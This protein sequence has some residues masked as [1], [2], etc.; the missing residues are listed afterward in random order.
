MRKALKTAGNATAARARRL[1]E[2]GVTALEFAI[3][4]P[5]VIL[6]LFFSLEMGL[7]MWADATLE[8]AAMRISRIAQLGVPEGTSCTQAVRNVLERHVGFWVRDRGTLRADMTIYTP[9]IDPSLP[10][11]D[12]DEYEPVC[13]AGGRGDMIIFRLGF[14]RPAFTGIMGMFGVDIMRYERTAIIQN[15][16]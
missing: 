11:F 9:G 4:A 3:V 6:L 10:D 14:D 7:A 1:L 5:L 8:V 16:P 15:E 12:D 13:D 2:R